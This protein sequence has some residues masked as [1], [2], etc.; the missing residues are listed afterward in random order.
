MRT[1][2]PI[3]GVLL[4]VLALGCSERSPVTTAPPVPEPELR[5][6]SAGEQ[7]VE[8]RRAEVSASRARFS[9][10]AAA[11]CEFDVPA[12]VFG[13]GTPIDNRLF[14]AAAKTTDGTVRGLFEIG[15]AHV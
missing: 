1:T 10:V 8:R 13:T 11:A 6:E 12:E 4:A 7:A 2:V 14:Y 5:A 15:R 9:Q 3:A